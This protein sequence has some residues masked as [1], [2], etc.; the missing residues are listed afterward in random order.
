MVI[1]DLE[2][3]VFKKV[4]AHRRSLGLPALEANHGLEEAARAHSVE[5]A[6]LNYFSHQSPNPKTAR[7]RQRV[8]AQSLSPK[9]L[10]E[11][12]FV[13]DGFENSEVAD[14]CLRNW[15]ESSGHRRNIESSKYQYMAVGLARIGGK[16]YITQVF[17][18]GGLQ[19]DK[20]YSDPSAPA[21]PVRVD[22]VSKEIFNL[23]NRE[24]EAAGVPR[25]REDTVLKK[26]AE[27]HSADMLEH[28]YFSH[29]SPNPGRSNVRKRVN[30]AG[31][32]PIRLSENIYTCTGYAP[33]TVAAM[34]V[35]A[36]MKSSGH[37]ANI[38]DR[39]L[40]AVG[41]G[42]FRRGDTYYV[43]QDFSGDE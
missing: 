32:D 41:V 13:S 26:A 36:W 25:L 5:M 34:T 7:V 28:G 19:F 9:S 37:R 4:N 31:A 16:C 22:G 42:V 30:L 29:W 23:I 11:N 15:L 38:L 6:T 10:A 1:P 35:E 20:V 21:T 2:Q 33:E 27:E 17:A 8:E 18:G 40:N 43:T 24:R 14:F 3:E 12:I 39:R